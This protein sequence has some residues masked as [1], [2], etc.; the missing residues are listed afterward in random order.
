[1]KI[2]V[3]ARLLSRP[4][5]GIGRYTLEMCR[6]LSKEANISLYLYSPAPIHPEVVI[7]LGSAN[8]RTGNLNN[9]LLRQLWTES[10]LPLWAKK[11]G[12]DVFW[13]PAHRLPRWLP[14]DLARVVTI[15]DLVWKYAGDT[16]RPLSRVLERYQM[17]AAILA[18]DAVVADSKATADAVKEE[19]FINP[20]KLSVVP[21]GASLAVNAASFE[22]LKERGINRPYFLFVGTLEPRKN[23]IRLL[24]AYSYLSDSIKDQATLVIAGGTGWGGIDINDTVADLG[25]RKYVRIL[26][27]VDES[28][29][30]TLYANALF[31]AMPSVYEGFGLPLVEAMVRGSPVLT[32]NNSSMP[33]VAGNAGLLIDPLDTQSIK[34]G[35]EE[36]ISNHNVRGALADNA[37]ANVT[38]FN[39]D[40][41]AKQ[42]VSVFEKAIAGRENYQ[43]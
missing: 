26:G 12:V 6:A 38:R 28:I 18:A 16:M 22:V 29:L 8:I 3:D 42:L 43:K 9:I 19:F 11:D 41:A 21:L 10:Y 34:N 33:E 24:T 32:S 17:P 23:L 1:M 13:G 40:N 15:H 20:N 36:L 27:Y 2:G 5:T 14:R 39:W 4:L 25:L 37:R 35:L 7:N 30:A 31:L